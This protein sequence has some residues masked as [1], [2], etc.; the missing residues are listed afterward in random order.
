MFCAKS[1]SK[2]IDESVLQNLF[3]LLAMMIVWWNRAEI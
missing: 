1:E 2:L 3:D